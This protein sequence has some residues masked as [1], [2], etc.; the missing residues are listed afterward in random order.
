MDIQQKLK[1]MYE[2]ASRESFTHRFYK[3]SDYHQTQHY[4][5]DTSEGEKNDQRSFK[6]VEWFS[7]KNAK[8]PSTQG[9]VIDLSGPML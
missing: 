5:S 8:E 2:R 3:T 7:H 9:T 1:F 6:Q 4:L